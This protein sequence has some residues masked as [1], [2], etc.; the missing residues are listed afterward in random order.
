VATKTRTL[1]AAKPKD[2]ELVSLAEA[3]RRYGVNERTVRRMVASGQI[4]GY[5]LG[6]RLIRVDIREINALITTVP[7]GG[8][9]R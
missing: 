1:P 4:T 2:R 7:T 5:R 3:A 6:S 8:V 9:G